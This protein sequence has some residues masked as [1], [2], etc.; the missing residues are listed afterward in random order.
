VLQAT[1]LHATGKDR[2]FTPA[3]G[4]QLVGAAV[5]SAL[6]MPITGGA[7]STTYSGESTIQVLAPVHTRSPTFEPAP[8]RPGRTGYFTR[9]IIA[10]PAS[11]ANSAHGRA[12][13]GRPCLSLIRGSPRRLDDIPSG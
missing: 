6:L 3:G 4:A 2:A 5:T 12:A 10:V 9:P 7:I 11:V 13:A 1:C 8:A